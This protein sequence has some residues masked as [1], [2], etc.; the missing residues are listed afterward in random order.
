MTKEIL[1]AS[2]L[3]EY[4]PPPHTKVMAKSEEKGEEDAEGDEGG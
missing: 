4:V 2:T 3:D 1:V